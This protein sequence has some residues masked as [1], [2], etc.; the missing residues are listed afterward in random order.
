MSTKNYLN[1][2]FWLAILLITATIVSSYL[3]SLFKD[4]KLDEYRRQVQDYE[5][6]VDSVMAYSKRMEESVSVLESERIKLITDTTRLSE[7]AKLSNI[8]A[9]RLRPKVDSLRRIV[10]T[11]TSVPQA[12][13][14][15]IAVLEQNNG[16]LLQG[17]NAAE[18][19]ANNFRQQIQLME[20]QLWLQK[21]TIDSLQA[22]I[23]KFPSNVPHNE[24]LF[25]IIP[26][27]SRKISFLAGSLVTILF[28]IGR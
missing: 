22:I 25:G 26:L 1:N 13:K 20:P 9:A 28:V 14:D 18:L 24:S 8:E 5:L 7:Q 3:T 10:D 6:V 19:M 4:T 2:I 16:I 27:P 17:K 12:A 23:V 11:L 21:Q 15:Y